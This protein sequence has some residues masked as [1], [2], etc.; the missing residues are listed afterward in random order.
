MILKDIAGEINRRLMIK[1]NA[2]DIPATLNMPE[3][4]FKKISDKLNTILMDIY[5]ENKDNSEIRMF[6]ILMALNPYFDYAYMVNTLLDKKIIALIKVEMKDKVVL[7]NVKKKS[8][9]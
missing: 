6:D 3:H 7:K 1:Q 4:M 2:S 9:K 5:N 8:N